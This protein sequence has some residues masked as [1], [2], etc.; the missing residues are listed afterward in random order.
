[1]RGGEFALSQAV[2]RV[3]QT[4]E[5]IRALCDRAHEEDL[6]AQRDATPRELAC[7]YAYSLGCVMQLA[8]QELAELNR[9]GVHR[10][11]GDD[12]HVRAVAS[13]EA[14]KRQVR[15]LEQPA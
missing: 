3:A 13:L 9:V 4:L 5:Q 10:A 12:A 11:D 2:V 6:L 8:L 15:A 14:F 7:H 1:M